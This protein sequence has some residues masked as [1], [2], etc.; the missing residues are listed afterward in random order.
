[1]LSDIIS[2]G[3]VTMVKYL[4][5]NLLTAIA[6]ILNPKSLLTRIFLYTQ[7]EQ[8]LASF[9]SQ[10]DQ[11]RK[12]QP[13]TVKLSQLVQDL[14]EL[15]RRVSAESS[16]LGGDTGRSSTVVNRELRKTQMDS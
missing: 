16:K 15:D 3:Y 2:E 1:M 10:L 5:T 11:L 13:H 9:Q 4:S 7:A 14:K 12:L 6:V 8:D